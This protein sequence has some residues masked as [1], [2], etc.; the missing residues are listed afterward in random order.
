[1]KIIL[2]RNEVYNIKKLISTIGESCG[3]D[4]SRVMEMVDNQITTKKYIL[5][6]IT[7]QFTLEIKEEFIL[8]LINIANSFMV[9][10]SETIKACVTLLHTL[11][12]TFDKYT[13]QYQK[14]MEEYKEV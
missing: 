2:N 7:G 14:F 5:T 3:D 4:V 8:G 10:S 6:M 1:M 11:V 12:P 13:K 9:E